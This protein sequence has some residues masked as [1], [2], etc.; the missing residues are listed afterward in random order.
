MASTSAVTGILAVSN[1]DKLKSQ[2][3]VWENTGYSTGLHHK[4]LRVV[5]TLVP[6]A[7]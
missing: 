5:L 4:Y 1:N 6:W 3:V 2:T 7:V